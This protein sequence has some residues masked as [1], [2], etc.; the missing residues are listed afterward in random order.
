MAT[1]RAAVPLGPPSG[2]ST[3]APGTLVALKIARTGDALAMESLA[4][5]VETF[6]VLCRSSGQTPCPRLYDVIGEPA[7]GLVMEWCPT[8]LERLWEGQN[9]AP[10]AF[11]E[12]VEA[13]ADVC[14]RVRE[15][16]AV[17]EMDLGR[18]VIHADIKPK[19]VLR[20]ADGRWLLTDFG[21]S[22]SRPVE[23]DNWAATRMVLGT[24]NFIAPEA[25]F[26]AR[27]PFPA[28]MDTWSIAC[29]LL[30]LLKMRTF[31]RNGARMPPNGTHSHHFRSH[32]VMLVSDLQERKP[33]L[34]LNKDLDPALFTSPDRLPDKDRQAVHDALIGIFDGAAQPALEAELEEEVARLLGRALTI[35]PARRY[36]D[37]L[38]L[39]ADLESL[40]QRYRELV[41][42]GSA[43]PVQAGRPAGRM[44]QMSA[45][46]TSASGAAAAVG[47]AAGAIPASS[48]SALSS[49]PPPSATPSIPA[50]SSPSSS[51]Q[52]LGDPASKPVSPGASGGSAPPTA[53]FRPLTGRD[54][55][56]PL[57][58]VLSATRAPTA[59]DEA[60][61]AKPSPA[62]ASSA[63]PAGTP[64]SPDEK[65]AP[66]PSQVGSPSKPKPAPGAASS[67]DT[68]PPPPASA[69]RSAED[70]DPPTPVMGYA[71]PDPDGASKANSTVRTPSMPP[72]SGSSSAPVTPL[73]VTPSMS[74]GALG[75]SARAGT[76]GW[77]VGAVVMLGIGEAVILVWLLGLSW[78]MWG[79]APSGTAAASPVA[80]ALPSTETVVS[81]APPAPDTPPAEAPEAAL[82]A[83]AAPSAE[84]APPVA[85][86]GVAVAPAEVAAPVPTTAVPAAASP[87]A[88]APAP[89]AAAPT[90]STSTPAKTASSAAPKSAPAAKT[91]GSTS[92]QGKAAPAPASGSAMVLITGA[93]AYLVGTAGKVPVGSVPAGSYE[94]FARTSGEGAFVSV[95]RL[96]LAAGERAV[97]KC[98]F[99]TC[100][101]I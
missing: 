3:V 61:S 79:L 31:L 92:S 84:A 2:R 9:R 45:P 88:A 41:V 63:A 100:R 51:G 67:S 82:V 64:P 80:V 78:W 74:P 49:P 59:A 15:Y 24:E 68:P 19:N 39:A 29:T 58:S 98:G 99:G 11:V 85:D 43:S 16:E 26:N 4:R 25:V 91:T 48:I 55:P 22:K 72:S 12:L 89:A 18:R 71:S 33:A 83:E 8:D 38:E 14:R 32:R 53:P 96:T 21:A 52:G 70:D 10:R 62:V 57:A 7:T 23:D 44:P 90:A 40:A 28:A 101:R 76:P 86:A 93:E 56:T 27:K 30:A 94:L 35:D 17:L 69:T 60:Q 97:Y 66:T 47:A 75:R 6:E 34:F 37:P 50:L 5:E 54:A 46:T 1:L 42:Q 36:C 73:S 95:G 20:S 13:L 81:P 77:L 87:P 65:P